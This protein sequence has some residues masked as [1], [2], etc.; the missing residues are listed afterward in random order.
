MPSS[1]SSSKPRAR[2][3]ARSA[4]TV[5]TPTA[6]VSHCG[7]RTRSLSPSGHQRRIDTDGAVSGPTPI[8]TRIGASRRT[9]KGAQ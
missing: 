2:S 5:G 8:A 9:T 3:R 6:P 4:M 1:L 7:I